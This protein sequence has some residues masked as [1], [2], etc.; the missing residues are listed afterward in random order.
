MV[1]LGRLRGAA[2]GALV[3]GTAMGG[4]GA[5]PP[6]SAAGAGA[7]SVSPA[8]AVGARCN[9]RTHDPRYRSGTVYDGVWL[10]HFATVRLEPGETA[11]VAWEYTQEF[12]VRAVVDGRSRPRLGDRLV[13]QAA[14]RTGRHLRAVGETTDRGEVATWPV[15]NDGAEADTFVL[16]R[17]TRT[18]QARIL[19]SSCVR[20]PG[21]GPRVG[22]IE[23]RRVGEWRSFVRTHRGT[24]QCGEA[25]DGPVEREAVAV[26]CR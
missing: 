11:D 19:R 4:L 5:A 26:A 23:W 6:A 13:A 22:R 8:A 17:G 15:T 16:W 20:V 14:R 21:R 3:V 18:T 10:T 12:T 25:S 1:M 2:V 24:G 7:S 9:P